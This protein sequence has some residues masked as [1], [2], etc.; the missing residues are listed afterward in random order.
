MGW[1]RGIHKVLQFTTGPQHNTSHTH[2][3]TES[4]L[5]NLKIAKVFRSAV[6]IVSQAQTRTPRTRCPFKVRFF[7]S[8][9]GLLH[10]LKNLSF[11]F[12]ERLKESLLYINL[13][14]FSFIIIFFSLYIKQTLITSHL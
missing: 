9:L 8:L 4:S 1:R 11:F 6:C 12:A 10:G 14:I 2:T 7:H 3:H 5:K 13:F